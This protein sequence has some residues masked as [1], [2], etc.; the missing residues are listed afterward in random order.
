VP[1]WVAQL[2]IAGEYLD[3]WWQTNLSNPKVMVEWLRG[4]NIESITAW[5]SALGG[6]LLHRLFLFLV[7]MIALFLVL[8]DGAW[9]ADRVLATTDLLL[10]D[11]GERL[12]SKI[13]D[14]IRGAVRGTVAVAIADGIILGMAYILA[15]V[16]QPLLFAVL[17]MAFAMVPFGAWVVVASAT[18]ILLIHGSSLWSAA[19]LIVLRIG[20]AHRR[21]FHSAGAHRRHDAAAFPPRVDRNSRRADIVRIGRPLPRS[22]DHGR[23]AYGLARMDGNRGL[24][25]SGL[26]EGSEA[27]KGYRCKNP[28][29]FLKRNAFTLARLGHTARM[30]HQKTEWRLQCQIPHTETSS[31]LRNLAVPRRFRTV[32]IFDAFETDWL[33]GAA[34]FEPLHLRIGSPRLSARGGRIRS[35]SRLSYS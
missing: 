21:Q 6:A 8:R 23:A 4:I 19:V 15:G 11:P 7:T 3:H 20:V 24:S 1:A 32:F 2:P 13:A 30:R 12:A 29:D 14:A 5:I 25:R 28:Q 18:L 33:V 35:T 27:S 22:G 26:G 31:Y 16:P 34:G 17:T 9:L 10:G